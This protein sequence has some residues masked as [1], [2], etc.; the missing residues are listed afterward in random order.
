MTTHIDLPV[1]KLT[2]WYFAIGW[3][4][5][6]M[7]YSIERTKAHGMSTEYD[8]RH[9]RQLEDMEQFLQMSWDVWMDDLEKNCAHNGVEVSNGF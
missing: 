2:P 3:A 7:I 8:E 6:V 5:Q 1:E 9:L 4:K